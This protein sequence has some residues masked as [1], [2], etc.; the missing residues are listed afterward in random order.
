MAEHGELPSGNPE[1]RQG[2]RV[3][4]GHPQL[5]VLEQVAHSEG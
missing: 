3:E 1:R 5:G 4:L 2:G